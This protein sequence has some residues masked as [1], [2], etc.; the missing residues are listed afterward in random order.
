M[1]RGRCDFGS[2]CS[3]LHPPLP[4][5]VQHN[6]PQKKYVRSPQ[7]KQRQS[8]EFISGQVKD[9]KRNAKFKITDRKALVGFFVF[10]KEEMGRI[11]SAVIVSKSEHRSTRKVTI[12]DEEPGK[13]GKLCRCSPLTDQRLAV[14][15]RWLIYALFSI[16][17]FHEV[18]ITNLN[19]HWL[20]RRNGSIFNGG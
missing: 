8:Q 16:K 10:V 6:S 17:I 3:F 7:Q 11:R 1:A 14:D 13:T 2:D 19:P 12:P 5:P 9:A 20:W 15:C 18:P 4:P